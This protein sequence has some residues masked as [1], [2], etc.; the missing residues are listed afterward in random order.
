[1]TGMV[2]SLIEGVLVT[3]G[4]L[5]LQI[6]FASFSIASCIQIGNSFP[7]THCRQHS[8]HAGYVVLHPSFYKDTSGGVLPEICEGLPTDSDCHMCFSL[9]LVSRVCFIKA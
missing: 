9:V 7:S 6:P 4:C 3:T 2:H 8:R 5:G 1:M